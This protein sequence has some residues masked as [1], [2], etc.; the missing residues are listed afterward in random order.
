[1]RASIS[2]AILVTPLLVACQRVAEPP[3]PGTPRL[4]VLLVADQMRGDYLAR[5]D[6]FWEGGFRYLLNHGVNFTDAYQDH[7]LTET[8]PGHATLS[9]GC[10][11]SRHGVFSNYWIDAESGEEVY[12]VEDDDGEISPER[13]QCSTLGDWMKARYP[14]ARVFSVSAKDRSAV[15]LGGRQADGAFFYDHDTGA[16]KSAEYYYRQ[17]PSWVAAFN[18]RKLLDRHFGEPWTALPASP[19]D[20]AATGIEAFDI[21]PLEPDLP[22]AFGDLEPVPG[23]AFYDGIYASPFLDEAMARFAEQLVG[24]ETL[25]GDEVPDLLALSF[26]AADAVG[27]AYGPDSPQL[28]DTMRRLDIA[29]GELLDFLEQRVGLDNVVLALSADHGVSPVPELSRLHGRPG[30]RAGAADVLCMQRVYQRLQG[31]FGEGAW[32]RPGPFVDRALAKAAG[33]EYEEVEA[34]AAEL[35]A[36]CP[37]VVKVW[38]RTEL[39]RPETAAHPFGR[40]FANSFPP[41]RAPD[42]LVQWDEFFLP[43]RT[44]VTSHGTAWPYDSHVP[45]V[46]A[47]RGVQSSTRGERVRTADL[48]PTLAG[49]VA[50]PPLGEIDGADLLAAPEGPAAGR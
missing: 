26:S 35:M 28:L 38:T 41:K 45:L 17:E 50:V 30:H 24:A 29:L 5:F 10:F 9:T 39:A 8:A 3:P 48:A 1:M 15:L 2:L 22:I 31:R 43:T 13:L 33:H 4:V 36:G 25:G 14:G 6:R 27:H 44:S 18:D 46:I 19:E 49:L 47:G 21:G 37:G 7:A 42:L 40:L 12:S 34:A 23:A 20:L 16:W 11:P 32:L